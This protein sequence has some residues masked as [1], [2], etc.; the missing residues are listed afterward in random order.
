M[1]S[2]KEW[3]TERCVGCFGVHGRET[4]IYYRCY[5]MMGYICM[6]GIN[7]THENCTVTYYYYTMGYICVKGTDEKD[8]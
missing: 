8:T 6:K 4:E 5:C 2:S 7:K 3:R 1:F